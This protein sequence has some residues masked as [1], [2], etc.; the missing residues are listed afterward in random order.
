[1]SSEGRAIHEPTSGRALFG[2]SGR[3]LYQKPPAIPPELYVYTKGAFSCDA[4]GYPANDH[5]PHTDKHYTAYDATTGTWWATPTMG[6]DGGIYSGSFG[7]MLFKVEQLAPRSWSCTVGWSRPYYGMSCHGVWLL[8]DS[9][10]SR[11][12]YTFDSFTV[13]TDVGGVHPVRN[14]LADM[15]FVRL[16]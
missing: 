11:G 4:T 9:G 1:M 8:A 7:G 14:T 5:A 3:A 10:I 15:L 6:W 2:A 16:D 13:D 12:A